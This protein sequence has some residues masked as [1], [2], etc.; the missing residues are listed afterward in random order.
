MVTTAKSNWIL[1]VQALQGNPYDGHTIK[2]ALEHVKELVGFKLRQATA[3]LGYHGHDCEDT[4]VHL[5]D[6]RHMRRKTRS[7]RNWFKRRAAIEPIF[8][9]LK[10]DNRMARN[11]LKG[12]EGDKLNALL[13][14][15]GINMRKLLRAFLLLRFWL[16]VIRAK[17]ARNWAIGSGAGS[18]VP[19]LVPQ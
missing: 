8:G 4:I 7:V 18:L 5:V 19:S 13:A 6:Y 16:G 15:C 3:D 14:A 2:Q 17:R 1:S 11:H 9:H 12:T 10:S